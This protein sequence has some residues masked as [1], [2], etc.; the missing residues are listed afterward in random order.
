MAARAV[1]VGRSSSAASG[2]GETGRAEAG[3]MPADARGCDRQRF[4]VQA[5]IHYPARRSALLSR[6][7]Q[8]VARTSRRCGLAA[9]AA[10][11][12]SLGPLFAARSWV[13]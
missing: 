8:G 10:A 7:W 5:V 4:R 2:L 12:L 3:G 6:A 13:G 1:G 9:P 11:C